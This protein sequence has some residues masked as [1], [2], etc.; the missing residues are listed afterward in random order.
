M[1]AVIAAGGTAGHINPAIAIANE[2]LKNEPDSEIV[3]IGCGDGMEG[4]LVPQAGFAFHHIEIHSFARSFKVKDIWFNIRSFFYALRAER[5]AKKLYRLFKPDVVIGCGGYV[6]GPVVRKAAKMGI[7][8]AIQE[9]NSFPGM[10]TKILA[11]RVNLVMA[12]TEDALLRI[13]TKSH[14]IVTGNPVRDEFFSANREKLRKQWDIGEK[15]CIVSFGGSLGA[16]TINELC[17]KL[18][19]RHAG[20]KSIYH[21]HATGQYGTK[22]VPELLEKYGV[23]IKDPNLRIVEYIENMPECFAAADLIISRA[24]A[25]TMSEI[26]ASGKASVLIPSPNVTENHQ[27]Y[28]AKTLEN[29]GAALLFEE[30]NI[31]IDG[32]S[33]TIF[34][35]CLDRQRLKLMG[36]N[37]R[38]VAVP[39]SAKKIY[40]SIVKHMR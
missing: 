8:T 22:L 31:D 24:G 5:E 26:S 18:I 1:R 3:F 9:Q 33:D 6:S 16:R 28:N 39:N 4:K 36:V 2:I 37:A 14:C 32:V 29:V 21:I 20:T 7:F 35:L 13:E 19:Q 11:K 40:D 30:K 25:I 34:R 27:F 10:T 15:T 23:D 38:R 17:A 12:A